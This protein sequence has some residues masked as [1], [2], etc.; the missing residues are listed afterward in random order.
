[1]SDLPKTTTTEFNVRTSDGHVVKVETGRF[2]HNTM[3]LIN[4]EV[5]G[6]VLSIKIEASAER[7][8]ND[9]AIVFGP[10]PTSQDACIM[11]IDGGI[12]D[13]KNLIEERERN[14][15]ILQEAGFRVTIKEVT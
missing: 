3:I 5:I 14:V 4:G 13:L 8:E 11:Y 10:L 15:K 2:S 7:D 9:L 1:M 6:R 12:P